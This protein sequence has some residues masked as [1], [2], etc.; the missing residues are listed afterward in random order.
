MEVLALE[1]DAYAE[2]A[3]ALHGDRS[4]AVCSKVE[5]SF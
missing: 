1:S 5:R 3:Y 2:S 4:F